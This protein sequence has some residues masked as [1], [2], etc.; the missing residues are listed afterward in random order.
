MVKRW[1]GLTLVVV[2]LLALA[3]F[4]GRAVEIGLA[5]DFGPRAR[6]VR[7]ATLVFSG[8]DDRVERALE[9]RFPEGA[10]APVERRVRLKRGSHSVGARV[11]Y[12]AGEEK[13]LTRPL[14]VEQEGTYTLEF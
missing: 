13:T 2:G 5:I 6:E 8:E 9:L 4:R 11:R 1:G 12:A 7:E 14:R 10:P 3:L